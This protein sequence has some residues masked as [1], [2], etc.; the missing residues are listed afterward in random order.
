MVNG[1]KEDG[2]LGDLG[3]AHIL[4]RLAG[5]GAQDG[6]VT[7]GIGDDCAVCRTENPAVDQVF[8]SDATIEGVHFRSDDDPIR[9]GRK[10]VSRVLSDIASMGAAPEWVLI[11][12][13]APK[14]MKLGS[15]EGIYEG[16]HERLKTFG[17]G[18]I[19]GDLTE[20]GPLSLHL[21]ASGSLPHGTAILRSGARAGDLIWSTGKLGGSAAGKHLDFS[22][23][24]REGLW[25][26]NSGWVHAMTDIS[27]GLAVDLKHLTEDHALG[28]SV[29]V[30]VLEA[31]SSVDQALYDGED[32]ELLFTTSADV[33][34]VM[35]REWSKTFAEPLWKVGSVSTSPHEIQLHDHGG[36]R[37]LSDGGLHHF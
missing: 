10:A 6:R 16:I 5:Y 4:S 8:T 30:R 37:L 3:E 26:R 9:V 20:G 12:V 27:D 31:M 13:V 22:P 32:F 35:Q 24:V 14:Q 11:N 36:Y 34:E 29:E 21:F 28:A 1:L 19:G 17:G 7:C 15:L 2:S 25:L 33:E 18:L 23:R